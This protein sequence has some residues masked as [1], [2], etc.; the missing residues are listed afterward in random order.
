MIYHCTRKSKKIYEKIK[1]AAFTNNNGGYF[2]FEKSKFLE[3]NDEIKNSR[4][5]FQISL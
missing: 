5:L 1:M 4:F 3:T 2:F